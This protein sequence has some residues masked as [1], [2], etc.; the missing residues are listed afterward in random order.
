LG[1][2]GNGKRF[3]VHGVTVVERQAGKIVR[4]SHFFDTKELLRQIEG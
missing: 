1:V 3:S 2:G 4:E